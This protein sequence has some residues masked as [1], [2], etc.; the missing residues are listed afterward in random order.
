MEPI[1]Q[2]NNNKKQKPK[3]NAKNA[4]KMK[5]ETIFKK[6]KTNLNIKPQ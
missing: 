2:I 1:D 5:T 3:T 6:R 4:K